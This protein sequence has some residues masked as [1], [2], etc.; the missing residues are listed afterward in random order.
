MEIEA[1][2]ENLLREP[3]E[4][5]FADH[6]RQQLI[7]NLLDDIL[8]DFAA[9]RVPRLA[10]AVLAY[11][12]TELPLHIADEEQDLFPCLRK[13]SL[14]ADDLVVALELLLREHER[15]ADFGRQLQVG[16]EALAQRR[17]LAELDRF[18]GLAAMFTE[19]QDATWLGRTAFSCRSRAS[20]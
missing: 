5:L 13:R 12:R 4:Y 3:I 2:P 17:P 18:L 8:S 15:D 7:C 14:P 1:I 19:T 11:L 20:G 16:L 9:E 10:A 6:F